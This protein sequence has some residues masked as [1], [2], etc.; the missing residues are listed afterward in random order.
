MALEIGGNDCVREADCDEEETMEKV[1]LVGDSI[2]M[3]Y[4]QF[5]E[6]ELRGAVEFANPEQNGGT[7]ANIL[8]NLD[9][10]VIA[11]SPDIVHLNCGLHDIKMPFETGVPAV[12][13]EQ[14]KSNLRAIFRRVLSGTKARLIWAKTTPVNQTWHHE[15]KGFDRF[16]ADVDAYNRAAVEVAEQMGVPVNDLFQCIM[17]KGRDRLLSPDGVHFTEE[18]SQVLGKR[19]AECIRAHL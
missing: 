10:W 14:Y 8:A 16:E 7:S 1:V 4:Q 6:E 17:D 2:R 5:V 19:V 18:G 9:S 13:L 15:R 12:A 3:G 11:P